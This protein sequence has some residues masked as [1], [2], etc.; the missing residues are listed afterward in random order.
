MDGPSNG[1]QEEKDEKKAE[2][3]EDE[4]ASSEGKTERYEL[5][6]LWR[7]VLTAKSTS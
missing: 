6:I 7:N 2:E 5:L 4:A 1:H 3:K